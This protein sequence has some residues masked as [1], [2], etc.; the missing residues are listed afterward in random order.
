MS[1]RIQNWLGLFALG[2]GMLIA[3]LLGLW[4][5]MSGTAMP[6]HSDARDVPSVMHS[7]PPPQW[8]GAVE[9]ARQIVRAGLIEQNLPGL[10]VAVGDAG[11]MVWAEGFGWADLE[12]QMPVAPETRFRIG[13]ASKALTSAA[14]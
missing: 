4:A 11:N 13:A 3:A 8:A 6:L 10:S 9:E 2:V 14:V 5:Y 12:N 1:D 7:S